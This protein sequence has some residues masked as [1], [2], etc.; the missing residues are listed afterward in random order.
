ML[1]LR[2]LHSAHVIRIDFIVSRLNIE[3]EEFALVPCLHQ[4]PELL[5]IEGWAA[6]DNLRTRIPWMWHSTAL[7]KGG[8]D[9]S[10]LCSRR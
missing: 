2:A 9:L 8:D 5:L 1:R 3:D 6:L 10:L 7:L 4:R